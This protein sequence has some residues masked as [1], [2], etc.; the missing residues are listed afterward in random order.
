ML[1]S[2]AE[3][4][5]AVTTLYSIIK[6]CWQSGMGP[7]KWIRKILY[8]SVLGRICLSRLIIDFVLMLKLAEIESNGLAE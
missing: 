6:N 1:H 5:C 2:E 3:C 8:F 7:C 4:K